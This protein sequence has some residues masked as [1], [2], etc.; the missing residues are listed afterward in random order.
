MYHTLKSITSDCLL[1]HT[2]WSLT[3][4]FKCVRKISKRD[5]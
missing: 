5:Y 4:S 2:I 3:N 1:F